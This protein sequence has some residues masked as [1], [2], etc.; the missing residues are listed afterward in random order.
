MAPG[1]VIVD[2]AVEA[3]GNVAGAKMG[4]VVK[5]KNHIKI[6]G[7]ANV[8]GRLARDASV[9]F[10]RNLFNFLSAFMDSETGQLKIDWDDEIVT[11]I[12]ITKDGAVVHERLSGAA[13]SAKPPAKPSAAKKGA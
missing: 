3:G 8:P 9:L 5:S 13:T 6:V 4:Q 10:G 12:L 7:H 2:L 11:G 1:S